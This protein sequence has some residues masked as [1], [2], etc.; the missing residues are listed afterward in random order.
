[1]DQCEFL[2]TAALALRPMLET[3]VSINEDTSVT[4]LC[5]GCVMISLRHRHLQG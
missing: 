3:L 4:T 5:L 2:Y 1:M